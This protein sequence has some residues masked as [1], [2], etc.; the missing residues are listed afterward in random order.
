VSNLSFLHQLSHRS[1]RVFNGRIRVDTVLVIQ[2]DVVYAETTQ[3]G[4][5]GRAHIVWFPTHT[6][7]LGIRGIAHDAK[8]GR[9]HDPVALAFDRLPN[10]FLVRV[11]AIHVR[12]I[13]KVDAQF[14]RAMDG[15]D[16]FIIVAPAVKLRH[17]HAA[18]TEGRYLQAAAA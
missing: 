3:A 12:G 9:Q 17:S 6:A 2:I 10:Q 8:L 14:Q 18:Q 15:C 4:F 1:D 13:E 7:H 11:R 16:R 5:A